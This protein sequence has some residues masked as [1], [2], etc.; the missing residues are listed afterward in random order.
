MSLKEKFSKELWEQ[1]VQAPFV[2]GFAVTA[3]DPGGL[4]GAFQE[5]SAIAKSL[6]SAERSIAG[7]ILAEL[8]SSEGRGLIKAGIKELIKGRS[9]VEASE[10][11]VA[12]LTDTMSLISRMAPSEFAS[13][14]ALV[15][16]TANNVAEAANE[17]GFMGF[18][19]VPVSDAEKKTL[20]DI[21]RAIEAAQA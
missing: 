7:E 16:Q 21:E 19:G 4:I 10:A 13:M 14:A 3:A 11:A 12:R 17:G 5:S 18:G 2:A 9:T 15:R 8:N 1:V 6:R 20:T